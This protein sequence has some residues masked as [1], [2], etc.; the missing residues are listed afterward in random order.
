M[1]IMAE[2]TLNHKQMVDETEI[3]KDDKGAEIKTIKKVEKDVPVKCFLARPTRS[4]KDA[5]ATYFAVQVS[6]L[7]EAGVSTKHLIRKRILNAGGALSQPEV[8][9]ATKLYDDW[10]FKTTAYTKLNNIEEKV[11]TQEDK[12]KL[13]ALTKELFEIQQ[14]VQTFEQSQAALFDVSCESISKSRLTLWNLVMLSYIENDDKK[15]VPFFGAGTLDERLDKLDD[16]DNGEDEFQ[17]KL[18]DE[19]LLYTSVYVEGMAKTPAEFKA[20]RERI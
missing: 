19:Y 13:V 17:R 18:K 4:Q 20:V 15:Q 3:T 8:D 9:E 2:W 1:N 6:Q 7:S 10:Y 11:K 14:Q 5:S 16:I 12:D